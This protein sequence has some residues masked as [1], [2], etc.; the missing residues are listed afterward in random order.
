LPVR[1][2]PVDLHKCPGQ[3][4]RFPRRGRFAGAQPNG[5]ILDPHCLARLQGQVAHDPV[6]LVQQAQHRHP[7]GHR[8]YPRLLG[9]GTRHIDR[10]RLV[11]GC[12]FVAAATGRGQRQCNRK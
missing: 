10:D 8:R 9:L 2:H 4:F 11:F 6:S 5:H 12:R 7:L 1:P 3:L